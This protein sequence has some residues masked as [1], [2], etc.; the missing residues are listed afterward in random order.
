MDEPDETNEPAEPKLVGTGT[1][2]NQNRPE[3][4]P[5]L[6]YRTWAY[7]TEPGLTRSSFVPLERLPNHEHLLKN[8]QNQTK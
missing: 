8:Q 1:S 6:P 5:D 3:P 2:W 4:E 7:P